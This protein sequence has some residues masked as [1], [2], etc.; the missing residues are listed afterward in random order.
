ML[1]QALREEKD[2]WARSELAE[3]LATVAGR[4]E[5]AEAARVCAAAAQ[6]LNQALREEK[7]ARARSELAEGLA[8][9]AGRLEPAEAARVCGGCTGAQPGAERGEG[10]PGPLRVGRGPGDGGGPAGACRGRTRVCGGCT[11]AQPGAERGEGCPGPLRVGRGPGD[12]GGPAGACRGRTRVWAAAGLL[13]QALAEEK[14]AWNRESLAEALAALAWRLE[15][16]EAGRVCVEATRPYIQGPD[17]E[18]DSHDAKCVSWLIQHLDSEAARHAARVFILRMVSDPDRLCFE[19]GTGG[20]YF[21]R[22]ELERFCISAMRPKIRRLGTAI[23]A[24]IGVSA[25][26][27]APSLPF[28]PTAAEP[29]PCRLTTQDLV[30]LLKMPTCVGEVR[31]V[32]LDQLGNRYRQYFDTHWDFVRYAQEHQLNLDFATPPQ[33]PDPKLPP[34]FEP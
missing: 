29:F 2:A 14:D 3:G 32:I 10:C 34:L 23:A 31:R 26:G 18:A 6:V 33:R 19:E 9:V 25:K 7:D 17:H 20:R 30:D 24:A 12:G 22:P 8:T 21:S 5:P 27:P 4:L 1:N 11:G 28:L 13:Q 15:P 16:A